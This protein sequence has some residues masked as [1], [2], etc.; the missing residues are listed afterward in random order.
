MRKS[1][2]AVTAALVS[3]VALVLASCSTPGQSSDSTTT[4]A[5]AATDTAGASVEP[6]GESTEAPSGEATSGGETPSGD[7]SGICGT[8]HGPYEDP[9]APSGAV[10]VGFNEL[11]SSFNSLSGHGNSV[12]NANPL[13]LIQ[14]QGG[15]YDTELG[16][17]NNDSFITCEL[18]SEDPLTITYTIN[19]DAKWSD[20]AEVSAADLALLWIAQSGKYNTGEVKADDEG[21]FIGAEAGQVAF[22]A[23]A[24]GMA[25]ITEFP[26][27][28]DDNKSITFTY[29][30]PFVDANLNLVSSLVPA[31][32]VG[33]KALGAADAEAGAA[34][35]ITAAQEDNKADLEKVANFWN[36]AFDATG[37]PSDPALYLSSGAY[38]LTDW[39]TD[40]FMTFKART[41][42][43][44]GPKP[45]VETITIQYAPDPT[46]AVQS[47]ANGE[48]QIIEPQ[49]TEDV[50]KGV[51]AL[52]GQGIVT[53][54]GDGGTYEHVDLVFDNGGPFDPKTYGGDEE[55]AKAVRTAFLKSI[56]RQEIVDRLIVPLN[57]NAT[58][59]NS[60]STVPGAPGYDEIVAESGIEDA[61][62]GNI[63]EAKAILTEAGIDTATPISVRLM[64]ADNNPRRANEYRLI[65]DAAAQ[66]G[67]TVVDGKDA[68]WSS[69]LSATDGYDASLFGWQNSTLGVGQVPP[70]FTGQIDGAWVGQNNFGH[71]NNEDVNEWMTTLNVTTDTAA[72]LPLLVDLEKAL[73]EDGF[74]AVIF[75]HP[76][77][78]AFDSSKVT[79]VVSIPVSP[80]LF[81]NFWEWT[82]VG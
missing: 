78:M 61:L 23:A 7:D 20:G 14:A 28:S 5:P 57:P 11:A 36:T 41:D 64:Y 40:E 43:T 13:Y 16:L 18:V 30:E 33:M 60:F 53:Q 66:V 76:N 77:I 4:A 1:R 38:E 59:R 68:S 15:Y 31:H 71:Y 2:A 46:A 26:E 65:A 49:A 6:S 62:N 10:T 32:V 52:E 34:A 72:Q 58:P 9:G 8:P 51:T 67:F 21:N 69:K 24:P 48:L 63:E 35:V 12:Y 74:G 54:S 50:L 81:G 55:K 39:K 73:V 45:K 27:I 42:Y 25:L 37:L 17:V 19:P 56:P 44:W 29:S 70:N 22:D 75:Q 3:G 82:P 47:L 80:T 79:G